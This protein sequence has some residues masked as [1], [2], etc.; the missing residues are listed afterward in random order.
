[1]LLQPSCRI[2][3]KKLKSFSSYHPPT[4]NVWLFRLPVAIV[5]LKNTQYALPYSILVALLIFLNAPLF[6]YGTL[7]P[8]LLYFK[9]IC[10]ILVSPAPL[11][12]NWVY[13][14]LPNVLPFLTNIPSRFHLTLLA[15]VI[16]IFEDSLSAVHVLLGQ[17]CEVFT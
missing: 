13:A 12:E 4:V 7:V 1:M 9:A 17:F 16:V 3:L 11:S 2:L 14:K 5:P 15:L 8:L 6:T 10:E